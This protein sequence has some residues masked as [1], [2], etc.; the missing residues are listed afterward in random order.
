M[1]GQIE[2]TG[3]HGWITT[4]AST[5][6]KFGVNNADVMIIHESGNVGIGTTQPQSKLSVNGTITATEVVVT[7]AGFADYVFKDDYKLPSLDDVE[8][9]IKENKHL[10]DGASEKE[11][12]KDGINMSKMMTLQM[13]K[14]EE[15]T[16]YLIEMKKQNKVL[17]SRIAALE[18]HKK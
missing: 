18:T 9:F 13:Q 12:V 11:V 14:I 1:K 4:R 6:L 7:T 2:F 15:L 8:L 5:P 3:Y 16:L 10:P 17:T